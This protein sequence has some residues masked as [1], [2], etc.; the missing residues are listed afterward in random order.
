MS[1]KGRKSFLE[2][3]SAERVVSDQELEPD[4]VV[5]SCL[6]QMFCLEQG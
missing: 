2:Q 4:Q 3:G 1:Q 5:E 6:G